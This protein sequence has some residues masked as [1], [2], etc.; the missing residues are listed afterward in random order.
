ML[1]IIS[2][3]MVG[4]AFFLLLILL[5]VALR[6]IG[7]ALDFVSTIIEYFTDYDSRREYVEMGFV[8]FISLYKKK[9][10]KFILRDNSAAYS[11][12]KIYNSGYWYDEEYR[13]HFRT[14]FDFLRYRKWIKFKKKRDAEE[15]R[16]KNLSIV[17]EDIKK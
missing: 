16:I 7:C 8:D 3:I 5:F 6:A 1:D 12:E 9:P 13:I 11:F 15:K 17:I 2:T 14:L 10:H 4:F